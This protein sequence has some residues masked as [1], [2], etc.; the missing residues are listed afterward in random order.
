M[1][2]NIRNSIERKP[3]S[4]ELNKTSS[5]KPQPAHGIQ[6]A[7]IRALKAPDSLSQYDMVQ[8]QSTVGNRQTRRLINTSHPI[9]TNLTVGPA[10]DKYEREAD[11]IAKQVVKQIRTAVRRQEDEKKIMTKSGIQRINRDGGNVNQDLETA[12]H[13][14]GST[15]QP[16]PGSVRQPL[17]NAFG[18]DFSN[19]KIHTGSDSNSMN[20][21][22]QSRAFTNGP[23]IFFK[24][25]EYNPQSQKGRELLAHELTHVIQQT[26]DTAQRDTIQRAI[27]FEI[28]MLVA[29]D[30]DGEDAP[31]KV[32]HY[33]KNGLTL[34]I[35]HG[36]GIGAMTNDIEK[37]WDEVAGEEGAS[38]TKTYSSILEIVTP[39]EEINTKKKKKKALKHI[40]DA[41]KLAKKIN[42]GT[43]KLTERVP[44]KDIVDTDS[45]L[46]VSADLALFPEVKQAQTLDAHIQTSV[47][48]DLAQ[49]SKF[50]K[51]IQGME[52]STLPVSPRTA[53]A[54]LFQIDWTKLTNSAIDV[55][56][57]M[58]GEIRKAF[59][60][61]GMQKE[62]K[63]TQ[64]LVNLGGLL[65]QMAL[66][67]IGGAEAFKLSSSWKNFTPFL[68]RVDLSQLFRKSLTPAERKLAGKY[69][70][71][72]KDELLSRCVRE[73][74]NP[75]VLKKI[76]FGTREER[77]LQ[78]SPTCGVFI[79]NVFT[80][81]SDGIMDILEEA[82]DFKPLSPESVGPTR[83]ASELTE[84][85]KKKDPT[86]DRRRG[87]V[88]EL[89]VMRARKE[90]FEKLKRPATTRFP[91]EK[92]YAVAKEIIDAVYKLNRSTI[93]IKEEQKES[94]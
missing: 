6:N 15:G 74:N 86:N 25:G 21:S 40:K 3:N 70:Q 53:F 26:H 18:S 8:L 66:Y 94:K 55:G 41:K 73:E 42:K 34:T 58:V 87:I 5:K 39:P 30:I 83:K 46:N 64:N 65:T 93:G 60:E 82:E 52:T 11:S 23:N 20:L 14:A 49:L 45:E 29:A 54:K 92:W 80:R 71:E 1:S 57:G 16:L 43:K 2:S 88:L 48:I 72:L 47:G 36:H 35:D 90:L 13:H 76:N 59:V 91:P 31:E 75:L 77:D 51:D 32:E 7:V 69:A 79:D 63:G 4:S 61:K 68:S 33:K 9:Q 50:F 44:L 10:N 12:I 22:L 17:E 27:G 56:E 85:S 19:V 78:W 62:L 89:R 84:P 24:H 28:E 81:D 37:K 38:P 67:L